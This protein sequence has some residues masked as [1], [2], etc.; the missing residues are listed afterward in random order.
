MSWRFQQKQNENVNW[1]LLYHKCHVIYAITV[2][3]YREEDDV[4][5]NVG[6]DDVDVSGLGCGGELL[7][8]IW[9]GHC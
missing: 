6:D 9:R 2:Q 3:T 5:A 4:D 7:Q 8:Q 1:N